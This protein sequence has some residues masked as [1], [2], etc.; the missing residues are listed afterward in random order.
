M[1]RR[2]H[3]KIS[4]LLIIGLVVLV[5]VG[6][7]GIYILST[8]GN[9]PYRSAAE[10]N[11]QDYLLN[12]NSLRGNVY[13]VTGTVQNQLS[14]NAAKGRLISVETQA[15]TGGGDFIALVVPPDFNDINIQKGQTFQFK[16]I[17]GDR[18]IL[19]VQELKKS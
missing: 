12:A 6:G 11:V 3:R 17:V 14:W 15:E 16:L 13:K 19:T 8:R 5:I 18:G 2:A 4:P 7:F 10:L 9:D 1:P